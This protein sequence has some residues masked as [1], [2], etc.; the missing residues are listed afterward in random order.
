ME[1]SGASGWDHKRGVGE[2]VAAD[3]GGPDLQ[4]STP[5]AA[6]ATAG[7]AAQRSLFTYHVRLRGMALARL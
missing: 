5:T 2:H 1:P 4:V 3:D 6:G 7:G